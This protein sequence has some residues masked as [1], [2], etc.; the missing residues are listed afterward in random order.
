V[1]N[2]VTNIVRANTMVIHSILTEQGVDFERVIPMPPEVIRGGIGRAQIDGVM[3]EAVFVPDPD[4][5]N[6]LKTKPI[7]RPEGAV[8]WYQWSIEHWG[9]KWNAYDTAVSE[10]ER[11]VRFDT[12]WSHPWPVIEALSK[13]WPTHVLEVAYAD[14]D[15][16][17]NFGMYRVLNGE[18]F[19][20]RIP[21]EGTEE[22]VNFA[23]LIKYGVRY[24]DIENETVDPERVTAGNLLDS[25]VSGVLP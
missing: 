4:S 18:E 1:P 23:S 11:V 3:Q 6:P 5:D 13:K 19:T 24:S 9:T 22:G 21:Y 2:H 12:A 16:G 15:L 14:E 7:P 25:V 10:D 20:L 17:H 8:D